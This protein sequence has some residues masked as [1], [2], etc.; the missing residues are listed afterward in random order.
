MLQ[1]TSNHP[2]FDQNRRAALVDAL[3][4]SQEAFCSNKEEPFNKL[5]GSAL[6]LIA[7]AVGA[8]R[9]FIARSIITRGKP[10]M[11]L[12]YQCDSAHGGLP[13]VSQAMLPDNPLMLSWL[14]TLLENRIVN[15]CYSNAVSAEQ[16]VM[17]ENS[18]KSL[19]ALPVFM[20][21]EVWGCIAFLDKSK[22]QPFDESQ[23]DLLHS[24]ARLLATQI[25]IEETRCELAES[26]ERR[27]AML[28]ATPLCSFLW[29]RDYEL[30]DCN[31]TTIELF[32]FQSKA[33]CLQRFPGMSPEHQPDGQLSAHKSRLHIDKAFD[34]GRNFYDWTY[35]LSDGTLM[36]A[37]VTLVRVGYRGEPAVVGFARD[38]L[39]LKTME[40]D[41]IR[42]ESESAKIYYDPLTG[43]FNRRFFDENL[44]RFIKTLSR[45]GGILS[46]LMID[47]DFFK[48]YNDAYGHS[49]GDNCLKLVS[50]T[51]MKSVT[52]S[53][54]FVVRYGGEEFAVVLPNTDE[55]GARLLAEKMLDSIRSCG[56][57]H[58]ASSVADIVTI[59]IGVTTGKVDDA[60][61]ADDFIIRADEQLYVSK[62]NGRNM[63]SYSSL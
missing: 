19:I 54:D 33:D 53:D 35:R 30:I 32:G 56:I 47:I 52:R 1:P 21:G 55:E 58:K 28:D 24:L 15:I 34:A 60:S 25:K 48:N 12:L 36:P 13:D 10:H 22:D 45:S 50:D 23:V 11:K 43:I 31:N 5:V 4:K 20:Q 38:L 7:E 57:Q 63:S 27:I 44:S 3:V 61:R 59:S 16:E 6:R 37:E 14:D 39:K 29:T 9:V 62:Q 46:M 18:I 8:D 40:S 17:A 41:I 42:L 51:L 2:Q 49:A 26:E